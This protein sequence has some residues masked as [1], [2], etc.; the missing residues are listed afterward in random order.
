MRARPE[1][2]ATYSDAYQKG[3][4]CDVHSMAVRLVGLIMSLGAPP[5]DS[6]GDRGRGLWCSSA[7]RPR[8][9]LNL[10]PPNLQAVR[11]IGKEAPSQ[12]RSRYLYM[13]WHFRRLPGPSSFQER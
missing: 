9:Q 10:L 2:P 7:S 4:E 6:V 5:P 1:G 3:A 12:N 11:S 8:A 13:I